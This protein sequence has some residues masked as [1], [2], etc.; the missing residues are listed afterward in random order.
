MLQKRGCVYSCTL[1]IRV[2]VS[3]CVS[4]SITLEV[5]ATRRP[6]ITPRSANE[7]TLYGK[8]GVRAGRVDICVNGTK[9]TVCNAQW[10]HKDA[11]VVCGQLGYSPYGN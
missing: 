9:G 6:L 2:L 3:S 1:Y 4:G 10:D 7:E 8:S 11:S 5:S